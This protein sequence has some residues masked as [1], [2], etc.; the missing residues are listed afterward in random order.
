MKPQIRL[1]KGLHLTAT[2]KRNFLAVIEFERASLPEV[3]GTRWLGLPKSPK[4]YA[5]IPDP[6][7]PGRYSGMIQARERSDRG[8]PILRQ[9][10]VVFEA[11][12]VD[13]LPLPAYET[14]DLFAPKPWET[15]T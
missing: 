9:F 14:Q 15:V 11:V 7:K 4:S 8:E 10:S 13:P 12:N 5:V 6:E 3:W 2:D 1:L